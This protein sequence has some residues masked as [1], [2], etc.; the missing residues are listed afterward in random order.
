M[1]SW[2]ADDGISIRAINSDLAG[3]AI[4]SAAAAA[5]YV[6]GLKFSGMTVLDA[7]PHPWL[8]AV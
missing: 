7:L 1:L 3:D 4:T 2:T 5:S 8:A 6:G